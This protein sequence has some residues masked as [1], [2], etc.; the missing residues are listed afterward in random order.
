MDVCQSVFA[1]FFVRVSVGEFDLDHPGDLAT[2]LVAMARNKLIDH[3]RRLQSKK[4]DQRRI[5]DD[6]ALAGVTDSVS[7]PS[8]I[9]ANRDLLAEVHSR[10]TAEERQ[11]AE[12]RGAGLEWPEI[13]SRL[14]GT[15]DG[16][17]KKLMRAV[18]RVS[19]HLGLSE[20]SS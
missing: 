6:N 10:L 4:R 9:V 3:V 2:L 15:P 7:T 16:L 14:G 13:A 5:V 20:F 11:V 19:Q 18:D 12:L 1:N 8:Q 17:R